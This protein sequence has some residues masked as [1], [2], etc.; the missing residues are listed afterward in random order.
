[1][2]HLAKFS[3]LVFSALSLSGCYFAPGMH[4]KSEDLTPTPAKGDQVVT[5]KIIPINAK[6]ILQL[7]KQTKRE[8]EKAAKAFVAPKDFFTNID[9]YHYHIGPQDI[10][11]ITVWNHP[12]ITNPT[13]QSI[14]STNKTGTAQNA[15]GNNTSGFVVDSQGQIYFP[16]IGFIHVEG[17]TIEQARSLLTKK[18]ALII[19]NPQVTLQISQYNSQHVQ[20]YGAVKQVKLIPINN[21]P[22]TI[23]EA[24][25]DAGGVNRCGPSTVTATSS[26][27]SNICADL[28]HIIL[29]RKNKSVIINLN[30]LTAPNGQSENYLLQGGDS[31]YVPDNNHS[32]VFIIGAVTR[33]GPYNIGSEPM[34]LREAFGDAAGVTFS[35]DPT[36]TYV[37]R[38]FHHQPKVFELDARSPDALNLAGDFTL[39]PQDI[40][41]VST[42][43]L[44]DFNSVINQLTPTL[45]SYA[46]IN[47]I[48]R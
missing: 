4:M 48:A 22:L 9:Q 8:Q 37:I 3:I 34:T 43:K 17:K 12:E 27:T 44:T 18:L 38:N 46:Y 36:Y 23:R 10:L 24:I 25:T 45:S 15:S 1:M 20:V 29:K 47:S 13:N 2:K 39:E 28:Q 11:N 40:V 31:I 7:N 32:R 14:L 42:S 35:S 6:L 41:F 19:K 33:P 21:I 26:P 30:S 16:Y 5:P